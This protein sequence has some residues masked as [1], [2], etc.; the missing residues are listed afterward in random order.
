MLKLFNIYFNAC[1]Q[2]Y[3]RDSAY[4]TDMFPEV[5]TYLQKKYK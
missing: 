1:S 4:Y 5:N 2:H 3:C